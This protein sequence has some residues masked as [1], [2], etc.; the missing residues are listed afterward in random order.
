M[1]TYSYRHLQVYSC[2]SQIRETSSVSQVYAVYISNTM[3]YEV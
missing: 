1:S 3:H 2:K